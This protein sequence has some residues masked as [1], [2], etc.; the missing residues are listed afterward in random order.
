M[1]RKLS[2]RE[3]GLIAALVLAAVLYLRY[4]G[5]GSSPGP[6]SAP[7]VDAKQAAAMADPPVVHMNLLA[8]AEVPYDVDGR[9]LFKYSKRPPTAEE[10][11]AERER[12]RRLAEQEKAANAARQKAM[13]QRAAQQAAAPPPRPVEPQPPRVPF[14]YLGYFGPK[15]DKIAVF[16]DN[17]EI[18]L[19]RAGD[20]LRDQFKLVEIEYE[21]AVIGYTK[22]EFANKTQKLTM[23]RR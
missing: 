16:E 14:K 9:D 13:E 20:V 6:S 7:P 1:A 11:A 3:I 8:A 18:V 2:R 22:P 19:A 5:L 10:L 4:G 21:S 12:L 23:S 17:K 15:D